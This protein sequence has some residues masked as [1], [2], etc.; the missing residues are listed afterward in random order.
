MCRQFPLYVDEVQRGVELECW[1]RGY[2]LMLGGTSRSNPDVTVTDIAGRVD[3]LAVFPQT[4]SGALLD[5]IARSIPVVVLSTPD[6]DDSFSHVTVDNRGGTR[7][8][9]EHLIGAHGMRDLLFIGDM[10]TDEN[11]QRFAGFRDTLRSAGLSVPENAYV[12]V[13]GHDPSGVFDRAQRKIPI[14]LV[15]ANDDEALRTM[16]LLAARGVAVPDQVAVTG[17]DGIVASRVVR[18]SLTTLRQPM[19][20]MGRAAVDILLGQIEA[21]DPAQVIRQLPLQLILRESCGCR[22]R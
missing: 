6:R 22:T 15:C 10:H 8:I 19:V 9:T 2:A 5:R 18:P 17:F 4:I 1:E 16:D 11:R 13:P 3:G 21:P 7:A 12:P 14:G 20:H